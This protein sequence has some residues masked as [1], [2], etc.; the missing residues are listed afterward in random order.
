MSG[1]SRMAALREWMRR[2][3]GSLRARRGDAELEEELR[4]HLELAADDA[5]RDGRPRASAERTAAIGAGGVAHTMEAM[6]DQR[7]LPWLDDAMRDLRHAVR[8]LRRS[9]VFAAIA[10]LSLAIGIGANCAIFSLADVLILRPLPVRD[11]AAIVTIHADTPDEAEF[12]GSVSYP[13]YRDLRDASRSF[14][15]LLAYRYSRVSFARSRDD[16]REMRRGMLV[17]DNFFSVLDVQPAFGRLFAADEGRVPGR[18]AVVVLS[19]DFWAN[20][21]GA[22][23]SILN[24]I[25]WMNG[26]DFQVVGIA[27]RSF[28]EIDPP[29]RPAFYVPL[30]MAQRLSAAARDP[31]EQRDVRTLTLKGRLKRGVS[32]SSARAELAGLWSALARQYPDA[33]RNRRVSVRSEV[34]E[35]MHQDPWDTI[36]LVLL[37]ALA[38][39]VLIIACA[40]VANLM[41]G[42]ARARS[43][44]MAIRLA[45][46]VSRTRLLRQLFT[47][48]IVLAAAGFA[49]GLVLALAGI[50]LLQTIPVQDQIVIS[51]QLDGRVLVFGLIV[52]AVSAVLFGMA[53]A[54]QS[55]R[56]DLTPV[57][58]T[59]E[60]NDTRLAKHFARSALVVGQ[61]ASSMVLLIAV[62]MLLDGFRKAVALNPG[63]RTDHLLTMGLDTSLVRSTPAQTHAFYRDLLERSRALPGVVSAALTSSVPFVPGEQQRVAV[64]PEGY[65]LPPGQD[66]ISIGSAVVDEQYFDT[67]RIEVIRGRKFGPAD[68]DGAPGVAVV[69]EELAKTYWPTA[70]A[71]G[72]RLRVTGDRAAWVEIV[73]VTRTGKYW[74][75]AEGPTPFIYLPFA[76]REKP[77]MSLLVETRN[78]DPSLMAT[79]LR[80]IVRTLDVNQP[81]SNVQTMSSLYRERAIT[82]PL[83][84]M[85]M[86]GTMGLL[87]LALALIGLYGLVAYSVARRTRE[88]GIRMAVGAGKSDVLTMVLRQGFC[89]SI[90]GIGIGAVASVVVARLLTAALVGLGA[91]NPATYVVVPIALICLTMAASYFPARRASLVDPLVALRYE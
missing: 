20:R 40:N 89:L 23:P 35:R 25:V 55:L 28:I 54:R 60:P 53:P 14:D 5:Q 65:R 34:D 12:G 8:L 6:R 4:L 82:V 7:G 79:P 33:N 90:I 70:D 62:G 30:M 32:Q 85:Q 74:W 64:V 18:D 68:K 37:G 61:I 31:L 10:I 1:A 16:A 47:E 2:L 86:V 21:L 76:Q 52:A 15:G 29:L 80:D 42:R 19:Y 57:L 39:V 27:P 88:I 84:I 26:I 17:S 87:G 22:D 83:L 48:G 51:P 73:G 72:K 41:L 46:G 59:S 58:K 43:R 44:E 67:M 71:V 69:N 9:P 50:R 81:I 78:A 91:P 63:F 45:L 3:L 38:A 11:A 75:I 49:A 66:S 13:N 36:I 56:T 24:S 77:R